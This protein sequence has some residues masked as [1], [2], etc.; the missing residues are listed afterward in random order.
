MYQTTID[1]LNQQVID[2][3][4]AVDERKREPQMS[5]V[6]S[7]KADDKLQ[8]FAGYP[9]CQAVLRKFGLLK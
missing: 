5:T 3:V 4:Y 1:L 9:K 2:S 6:D 8:P 7:S